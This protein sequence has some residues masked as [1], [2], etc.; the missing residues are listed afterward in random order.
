LEVY[1]LAHAL[2]LRIHALSLRLPSIESF[3]EA[4]QVRR[5][6]K[7]VAAQIVEGHALRQYKSEYVHYLSRAYASAEETLEHLRLLL[8]SGSASRAKAECEELAS[9]Y[10]LLSRKLFNYLQAIRQRHDPGRVGTLPAP[11]VGPELE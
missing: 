5:T 4:S 1:R 7:S 10:D 11:S 8:E 2:A 6:S 9:E 3:E